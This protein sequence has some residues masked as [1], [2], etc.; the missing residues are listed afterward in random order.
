[1]LV[2]V[3]QFLICWLPY[4]AFHVHVT[5]EQTPEAPGGP[6][7]AV[8]W[9]AYSSFAVNPF[10]YGLLNR[11]IREELHKLRRCYA[12]RPAQRDVSG[13]HENF[14]QVLRRSSCTAE[15]RSSLSTPGS[16][17]DHCEQAAVR[18][19]GQIPEEFAG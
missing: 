18:I 17:L 1:M 12:A 13:H 19:P 2:I 5:L 10:F 8:T 7:E 9:L 15:T 3:G 6:E 14:L 4:F 11:Q 16:S